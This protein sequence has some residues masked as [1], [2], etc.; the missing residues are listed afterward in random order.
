MVGREERV[1]D[2]LFV[3]V[4]HAARWLALHWLALPVQHGRASIIPDCCILFPSSSSSSSLIVSASHAAERAS[5][6]P[7]LVPL[8]CQGRESERDVA[9][10]VETL[11]EQR[12]AGL[13]RGSIHSNPI[14]SNANKVHSRYSSIRPGLDIDTR[15]MIQSHSFPAGSSLDWGLVPG[16]GT[17]AVETSQARSGNCQ[18]SE[19]IS[20]QRWCAGRLHCF[21]QGPGRNRNRNRH[22]VASSRAPKIGRT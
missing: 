14:P 22:L 19:E 9:S 4:L 8:P 16:P 7:V 17:G 3:P 11:L 2:G 12:H 6:S 1:D 18:A 20:G 15:P 21:L 13:W 5:T 10:F